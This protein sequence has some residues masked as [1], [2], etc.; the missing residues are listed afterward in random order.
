MHR[1]LEMNQETA[2]QSSVAADNQSEPMQDQTYTHT[3]QVRDEDAEAH[4]LSDQ[5]KELQALCVQA[6]MCAMA[7]QNELGYVRV[8]PGHT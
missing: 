7:L 4:M 1:I 3:H 6:A 5:K 2:P 8:T